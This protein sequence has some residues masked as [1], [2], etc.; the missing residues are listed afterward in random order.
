MRI[1]IRNYLLVEARVVLH[2][3]QVS[4]NAFGVCVFVVM[5]QTH[6]Y[7]VSCMF[8]LQLQTGTSRRARRLGRLSA[9]H[10]KNHHSQLSNGSRMSV[11]CP[12]RNDLSPLEISGRIRGT[13][14]TSAVATFT[15]N[16]HTM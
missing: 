8:H 16:I 4:Q 9:N 10:W 11:I 3:I 1:E 12:L 2:L 13:Q 15:S 14:Y 5:G 6:Y 7:I